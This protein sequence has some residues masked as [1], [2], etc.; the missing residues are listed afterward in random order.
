MSESQEAFV[1][2]FA[3]LAAVCSVLI[4]V[5]RWSGLVPIGEPGR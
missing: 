4:F 1:P 3:N 2:G 5:T